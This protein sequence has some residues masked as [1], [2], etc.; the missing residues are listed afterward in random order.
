MGLR[1]QNER[2]QR[3]CSAASSDITG[4]RRG[5]TSRNRIVQKRQTDVF[6]LDTLVSQ[7][8]CRRNSG[9]GNSQSFKQCGSTE[10]TPFRRHIYHCANLGG[11][12]MAYFPNY[13]FQEWAFPIFF[14]TPPFHSP[15]PSFFHFLSKSNLSPFTAAGQ[16]RNFL[17]K[18]C[19]QF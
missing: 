4:C 9:D 5:H 14:K 7:I 18:N 2:E 3:A 15:A 6:L 1:A 19:K 10:T 17:D 13:Q 16:K 8:E 11:L 12:E